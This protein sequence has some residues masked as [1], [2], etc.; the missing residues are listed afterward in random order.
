MRQGP[1][2]SARGRAFKYGQANTDR[3]FCISRRVINPAVSEGGLLHKRD[4][5]QSR[6]RGFSEEVML[7]LR[8][9]LIIDFV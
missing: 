7:I 6:S 8:L 4:S 3:P 1:A 2:S 5:R 9:D